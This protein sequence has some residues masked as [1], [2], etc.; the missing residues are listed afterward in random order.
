MV[1]ESIAADL[2]GLLSEF[3]EAGLGEAQYAKFDAYYT[4]FVRWNAKTNLSAIRDRDGI[5]R[6]HFVESIRCARCLPAGITTLLDF[7]SGGGLPGV[8]V[9][10]CR[11]ELDVVLAESQGKK[12]AFLREVARV[13]GLHARVH[14]GRAEELAQTFDCVT[15]R[16][17]DK[18][19]QAVRSA[20]HLVAS[21][22][23]I[24]LLT[25]E[26]DAP[27]LMEAAGGLFVWEA[28]TS[29]AVNGSG[30]LRLGRKQTTSL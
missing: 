16:A 17:V 7:G 9:S 8:P 23:W 21:G 13:L 14:G 26:R 28:P 6:R 27:G 15:M 22:G 24:G 18:M 4:L 20:S 3:H 25:T 29:L 19:N 30:I 2:A 5:L 11:P 10:I 12:S 1:D